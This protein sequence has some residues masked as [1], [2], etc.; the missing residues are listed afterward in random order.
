M[1]PS[2]CMEHVDVAAVWRTL[3]VVAKAEVPES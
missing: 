1:R 3:G 2:V